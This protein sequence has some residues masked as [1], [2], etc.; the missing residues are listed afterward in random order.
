MYLHLKKIVN[1]LSF[2]FIDVNKQCHI[3][4]QQIADNE[5]YT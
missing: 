3:S 2:Q 4:I 1:Y 5:V